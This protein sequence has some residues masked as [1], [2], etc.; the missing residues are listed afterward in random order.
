PLPPL[1][2]QKK[3]ASF[4]EKKT[5]EIDKAIE[6]KQKEN[7]L[8]KEHRQITINQA[9]TRGLNPNVP[10]KDSGIEWI[11]DIPE[12]WEVRKLKY[13]ST[14][15]NG[16]AFNSNYYSY[17]GIPI[18]RIGDIKEDFNL[19]TCPKYPNEKS[20]YLDEYIISKGCVFLF[21]HFPSKRK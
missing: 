7:G 15:K 1:S 5:A 11:G 8:L 3:I 13:L 2:E 18:M 4:L 17:V 20:K 16:Y 10:L 21:P 12:H 6:L 9:V 19:N 14:F